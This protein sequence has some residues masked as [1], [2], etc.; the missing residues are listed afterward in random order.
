MF[1]PFTFPEQPHL[2]RSWTFYRYAGVIAAVM[3]LCLCAALE[4][5]N[6]AKQN[7]LR[8]LALSLRTTQTTQLHPAALAS[9]QADVPVLQR[10]AAGQAAGLTRALE[11]MRQ[12]MPAAQGTVRGEA[13]LALQ[14][15]LGQARAGVADELLQRQTLQWRYV[16]GY[17]WTWLAL[18]VAC[19]FLLRHSRT[20]PR[21]GLSSQDLPADL[22]FTHAPFAIFLTDRHDRLLQGNPTFKRLTGYSL[23]ERDRAP[24]GLQ[25]VDANE[26][27]VIAEMRS[28]LEDSG[29]W[30]GEYRTRAQDGSI[31]AEQVLRMALCDA[32]G[33]PEGV[34]TISMDSSVNNQETRLMLWQ[35]H[36]DS[37]TKL[38]NANYLSDRLG[39]ALLIT[40]NEGTQ[41]ALISIDLDGFAKINDSLGRARGDRVLTEAAHRIALTIRERDTVAR[42]GGDQFAVLLPEIDS[43]EEAERV[44]RTALEALRLPYGVDGRDIFL[45]GSAGIVVLPDDGREQGDLMQKVDAAR[46]NAKAD[47]GNTLKYF[48][49]HMNDAA[50]RRLELEMA[51]RRAIENDE[52]FLEYQPIIDLE[53]G[54]MMSA[55]ALLRWH[56]KTLGPLSPAEFVPVAEDTGLIAPI[57]EWVIR[58]VQRQTERWHAQGWPIR[59]SVNVSAK[60]FP[61]MEAVAQLLNCFSD[62][63]DQC[64]TVELTESALLHDDQCTQAFLAGLRE[65]NIPV[66]LDD[67]G[68]GYSSI[69]YL[70]DFEF[71]VL[72]V[73]RSFIARLDRSKDFGLVA[74]IIALGKI[75][76]MKVVVE[77]VEEEDQL[78]QLRQVGCHFVQGFLFSRPLSVPD[79]VEYMTLQLGPGEVHS[80]SA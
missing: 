25:L 75:L 68:T 38:P 31:V 63:A 47:G 16:N 53:E 21:R 4:E 51:L 76:G 17:Y 5:A 13:S 29:Q 72:K 70:R 39:R 77:G 1:F 44:A 55:E 35:A 11:R 58:N 79:F 32:G 24:D 14:R 65:R 36:H 34:L 45:S 2:L 30:M 73:D 59:V 43:V 57:G 40:Q 7:D 46:V 62:Q 67:F 27:E 48:E 23:Q 78:H 15:A 6:R 49:E 22:I 74:S 18:L 37:L 60:Q 54:R 20:P 61:T 8:A 19:V 12:Q 26:P 28:A 64:L 50:A 69:G 33:E 66:A 80:H 42:M 71:D 3:L 9:L 41:G 56:H 10:F 52:F